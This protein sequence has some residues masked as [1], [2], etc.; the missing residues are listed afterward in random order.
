VALGDVD[1]DGVLD[2]VVTNSGSNNV[3]VLL[4]DGTGS[5]GTATTF[6]TGTSPSS[7]ALGDVDRDGDLDLVV[8]NS[9]ANT[10]SVLLNTTAPGAA[11]PSFA[12]AVNFLTGTTPASV[13]LGDVDRDGD[14]DLVVANSGANNVSVLINT[15]ASGAVTPS[16]AAAVNFATGFAPNSLA[17]GD[18]DRDGKPDIAVANGTSNTV[19][20]LLNTTP[21]GGGGG[22]AGGTVQGDCVI[23]TA[24]FGSSLAPEVQVLRNFRDR[25]LLTHAP[26][27][28][29]VA[30]YY[31][32]SPP[33]AEAIRQH[34]A[35]R[36]TT[37]GLLRPIVWWVR[38]ALISPA[39]A[40]IVAGGAGLGAWAL[41]AGLAQL[42]RLR[43]SPRS[44]G[45]D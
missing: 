4:G 40:T 6:A 24:A 30:A 43:R 42:W 38:I 29:L 7:V 14:L 33:L 32:A 34:E 11:L 3:S 35:L 18:V 2:L 39:L 19:S 37:R 41:L 8:A 16:F 28:F 36:A 10:V 31:R 1:R 13:A 5:F 15:T 9:G 23:A 27:R 22:G 25:A 17:L 26:G 44:P 12:A 21:S 45:M 20:V